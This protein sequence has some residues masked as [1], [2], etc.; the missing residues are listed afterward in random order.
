MTEAEKKRLRRKFVAL[1]EEYA[2]L[3]ERLRLPGGLGLAGRRR[4]REIDVER[5][6]VLYGDDD[7]GT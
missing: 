6:K 4:M 1:C 2:S 3:V 7:G 5:D